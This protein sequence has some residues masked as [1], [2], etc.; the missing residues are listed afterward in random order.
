MYIYKNIKR[1]TKRCQRYEERVGKR[2][3]LG[4]D[5]KVGWLYTVVGIS[6]RLVALMFL[7]RASLSFFFFFFA[8]FL[9]NSSSLLDDP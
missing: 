9:T 7:M 2:R 5:I 1:E 6:F 4:R 8:F 3:K